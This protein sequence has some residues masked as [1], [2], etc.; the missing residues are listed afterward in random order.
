MHAI[1]DP[2][3]IDLLASATRLHRAGALDQAA[4]LYEQAL[5]RAPRHAA[6]WFLAGALALSRGRPDEANRLLARALELRPDHPATLASA[7][8]TALH[9]EDPTRAAQLAEALLLQCPDSV[10]GWFI[11][12][13]ARLNLGD[14]DGAAA[15][16]RRCLRLAPAHAGAH[17]N[18]ANALLGQDDMAGALLHA[19][20]ACALAPDSAPALADLGHIL[21][22]AGQW[23]EAAFSCHEALRHD[24]HLAEAHWTHGI[25]NLLAGNWLVGWAEYEWR[26]RNPCYTGHFHSLPT[27]CWRGE[28]LVGKTLLIAAEQGL[29]DAIMLARYL[30]E[31]A[32]RGARCVLE[33]DAGLIPL[34]GQLAPCTARGVSLP[35]HDVWVDQMSLPHRFATTPETVPGAAGYLRPDPVRAAGWAARLP[36][37][38]RIGLVWAGNPAHQDDRLRSLP[39]TLLGTLHPPAGSHLISLQVGPRAADTLGLPGLHDASAA[40][41]DWAETAALL[42]NLDLL[43]TIDSAVAH[44]AGALGVPTW[45]LL[46]FVPDWR[47]L[48][49][50]DDTPWYDSLLLLRQPAPGD[51]ASVI[52]RANTLLIQATAPDRTGLLF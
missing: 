5:A 39:A 32:H 42:A 6:G 1:A 10:P 31:L 41:T 48:P 22:R 35:V 50:R 47:W 16:L 36:A 33:C 13:T 26:R 27:P 19:R 37:G 2:D 30:P 8:E 38:R 24:P 51:W 21:I 4:S 7:A 20:A 9:L 18:L 34:L 40:L 29:G 52:D 23:D 25:A 44:C 49:G 46:P 12:G 45:L 14:N 15:A 3:T 17:Q 43:I 28:A 11:A